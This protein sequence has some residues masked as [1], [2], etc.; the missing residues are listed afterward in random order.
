[1][2][3]TR[4]RGKLLVLDIK[5][6]DMGTLLWSQDVLMRGEDDEQRHRYAEEDSVEITR[7]SPEAKPASREAGV[8][9]GPGTGLAQCVCSGSWKA[10]VSS[11]PCE[12]WRSVTPLGLRRAKGKK[13]KY[14]GSTALHLTGSSCPWCDT[15]S[16]GSQE[17]GD[18]G[19]QTPPL[20]FSL[21]NS[22][23]KTFCFPAIQKSC[24]L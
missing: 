12:S 21:G 22:R 20:G 5:G 18:R 11:W 15:C 6:R 9:K 4:S 23:S 7:R 2:L 14:F 1:M 17:L 24:W 19:Y 3:G 10:D 13:G 16:T 8:C